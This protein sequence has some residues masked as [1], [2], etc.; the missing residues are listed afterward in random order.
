MSDRKKTR[1]LWVALWYAGFAV[2]QVPRGDVLL[3]KR[4]SSGVF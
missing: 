3:P 4:L 1:V 2:D